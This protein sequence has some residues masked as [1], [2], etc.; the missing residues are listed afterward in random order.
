MQQQ[1]I[2]AFCYL[3]LCILPV[4]QGQDE[5]LEAYIKEAIE[6]NHGLKEQ[7][8]L[9]EK[10]R[11]A[12]EE[13][14]QLFKPTVDFGITYTVSAGG[15][16]ISFP[17][18]DIMNPVYTTLNQLTMT[19]NFPQLE[20]VEENFLPNNFYD[21]RFRISQPLINREI[22]YNKQIKSAFIQLKE[23]EIQVFKRELVMEVKQA[24]FQYL[25]AMDAVKIFDNALALLAENKRINES[26]LRNDKVIPAVLLRI[27]SEITNVKA[28]KNEATTNVKNAAAYLNFLRNT[29]LETPIGILPT[30]NRQ[31][32]NDAALMAAGQ[33][34]ELDQ[35][36][37]AQSINALVVDMENAYKVPQLGLQIDL[38]SQNFNFEYG[39]YVLA[40]LSAEIPIYAANR[41]KLQVQQAELDIKATGEKIAAAEKQIALQTLTAKNEVIA[42][43]DTWKS[44]RSQLTNSK[45][46]YEDTLRRYKEGVSNYI[47]LLDARTQLTNMTLQQ[48]ISWYNVLIKEAALE[49]AN[50][51]YPLP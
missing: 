49:R 16:N 23:V 25:Q 36:N 19:T 46:Q 6:T 41:N 17:I 40:G 15:R 35:L 38:G 13:A 5:V 28:Q 34:E 47:E 1:S 7:S 14:R 12:L 26:L 24:Y 20:N 43:I 22:Y 42:T 39:G 8:F 4:C 31:A 2:L 30:S 11:L 37:V 29:S 3:F 50:A 51:S 33:R 44:Y 18:G 32:P 45:R 10:N 27:E 9:L 21:A 48:S